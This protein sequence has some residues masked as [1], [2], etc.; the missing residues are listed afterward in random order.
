M[1]YMTRIFVAVFFIVIVSNSPSYASED[2]GGFPPSAMAVFAIGVTFAG[3]SV[4]SMLV[5]ASLVPFGKGSRVAGFIGRFTGVL[6]AGYSA[7]T[8]VS[9]EPGATAFLIYGLFTYDLGARSSRLSKP[10]A[11]VDLGENL[12]IGPYL[13]KSDVEGYT[14]GVSVTLTR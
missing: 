3:L 7:V 11:S 8:I 10:K 1:R 13:S 9:G 14:L 12:S 6:I 2:C 4:G 5:N